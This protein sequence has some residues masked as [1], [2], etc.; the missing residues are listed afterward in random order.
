M[1]ENTKVIGT[2][3]LLIEIPAVLWAYWSFKMHEDWFSGT[4][5]GGS[6]QHKGNSWLQHTG[7][8]LF[9]AGVCPLGKLGAWVIMVW[10]IVLVA[11]LMYYSRQSSTEAH[12][13][14]RILGIVHACVIGVIALLSLIMNPPLFAR[15][16]PYYIIQAAVVM[17]LV[18]QR[19]DQCGPDIRVKLP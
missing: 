7:T 19:V 11:L 12:K 15:T 14:Y 4:R 10:T 17:L 2:A 13:M 3:L 18:G 8:S 1:E 9:G 5:G 16:L 6:I